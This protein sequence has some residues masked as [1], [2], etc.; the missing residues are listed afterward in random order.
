M[1]MTKVMMAEVM[2]AMVMAKVMV[3]N[4][5][6]RVI[7]SMNSVVNL[8]MV[9]LMVVGMVV[10]VM[11]VHR[12]LKEGRRRCCRVYVRNSRDC[13]GCGRV[14]NVGKRERGHFGFLCTT[15]AANCT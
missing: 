12:L 9:V 6:V 5:I 3:V 1:G 15:T 7:L 2:L 11:R 14:P 4:L 8:G 13:D 10:V